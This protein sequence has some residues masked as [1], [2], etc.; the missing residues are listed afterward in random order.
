MFTF[1]YMILLLQRVM[2]IFNDH[3]LAFKIVIRL[4]LCK[5]F[6]KFLNFPFITYLFT[7]K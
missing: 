6:L 5:H 1:K 7:R 2:Y 3:C 4:L